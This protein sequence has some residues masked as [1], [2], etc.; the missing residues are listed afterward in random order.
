MTRKRFI[1]L[2]MSKG[3]SR[4]DAAEMAA[5]VPG[6]GQSYL[7]AYIRADIYNRLV[8]VLPGMGEAV[9][10]ATEALA[11]I[12]QAFAAGMDAFGKAYREAMMTVSYGGEVQQNEESQLVSEK[13]TEN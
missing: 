11:K 7:E 5:E 13:S 4:N 9:Q 2:L 6:S 12:V 3:Y 10:R 1:K 8:N